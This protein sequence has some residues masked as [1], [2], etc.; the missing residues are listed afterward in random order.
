MNNKVE[1]DDLHKRIFIYR[2]SVDRSPIHLLKSV[3][4]DKERDKK[5]EQRQ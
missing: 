4:I 1:N 5:G 3:H 2:N